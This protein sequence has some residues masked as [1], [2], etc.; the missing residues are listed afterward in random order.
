MKGITSCKKLTGRQGCWAQEAQAY[1]NNNNNNKTGK[2]E[3]IDGVNIFF[4]LLGDVMTKG[5][6]ISLQGELDLIG[7]LQKL[8][9]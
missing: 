2:S 5:N 8:S 4:S 7:T 3:L 6:Y 9:S 1:R